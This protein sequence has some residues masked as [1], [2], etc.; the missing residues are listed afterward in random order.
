MEKFMN[1]DIPFNKQFVCLSDV[2]AFFQSIDSGLVNNDS[3]DY[4]NELV[5]NDYTE[6][7][8]EM[9]RDR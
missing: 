4:Y 9:L 8:Q 3:E 1:M 7:F 6:I 5:K 2:T